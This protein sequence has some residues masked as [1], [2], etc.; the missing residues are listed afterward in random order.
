MEKYRKILE[1][2]AKDEGYVKYALDRLKGTSENPENYEDAFFRLP[3]ANSDLVWL[4]FIDDLLEYNY[5]FEVDWK[6]D[7]T[8]VKKQIENLFRKKGI[9]HTIESDQ[10][11]YDFEAENYF[12]RINQLLSETNFLL[13]YL[14]ID[15][16]SYV[17]T[18]IDKDRIQMLQS[19]DKRIKLY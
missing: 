17:T 9:L 10:D 19:L 6:E 8:E 12:P 11:L 1:I 7:Y 4:Q 13:V 16:D 15:S 14:D 3:D 18:L 2:L 5:A